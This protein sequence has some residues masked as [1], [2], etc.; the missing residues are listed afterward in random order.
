MYTNIFSKKPSSIYNGLTRKS[1]NF[2]KKL[3]FP[4]LSNDENINYQINPYT[5]LVPSKVYSIDDDALNLALYTLG[6]TRE[7]F[8]LLTTNQIIA[9]YNF[10]I[11]N[12]YAINILI[13]HKEQ[14]KKYPPRRYSAD[15]SFTH[16][17]NNSLYVDELENLVVTTNLFK[18]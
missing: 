9:K 5:D 1:F 3:I 16:I 7:E 8:D 4:I 13:Y 12:A 2:G 14:I 11:P 10:N 6:L 17:K 18:K 15:D